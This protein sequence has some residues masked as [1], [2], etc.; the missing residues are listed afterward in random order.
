MLTILGAFMVIGCGAAVLLDI[1][2][3][4]LRGQATAIYFFVISLAGIGLGPTIVAIF[5]DFVFGD[6]AA[7]R[8]S[9]LI[10]PTIGFSL[11]AL[12]FLLARKPYV[13][14]MEQLRN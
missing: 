10:V 12:F 2:P 3:N 5:T 4:R 8:Y 13:R 11:G 7:V 14:S 6:P 9:L 1:M